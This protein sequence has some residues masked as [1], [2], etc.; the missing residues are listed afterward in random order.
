[1]AINRVNNAIPLPNG[2]GESESFKA[3]LSFTMQIASKLNEVVD[4]L[5]EQERDRLGQGRTKPM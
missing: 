3:L 4:Y 2:G 5:D 1:M